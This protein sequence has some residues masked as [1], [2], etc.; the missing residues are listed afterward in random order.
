[1]KR[2]FVAAVFCVAVSVAQAQEAL[3]VQNEEPK[4]SLANC[5]MHKAHAHDESEASAISERGVEGMGFSQ[6]ATTHHFFLKADGGAIQVEANDPADKSIRDSIRLHLSHIA[7]A[8]ASGD[9][10]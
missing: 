9:C 2:L 10:A 7:N 4:D 5:P 1:M 8:F 6:T 3:P